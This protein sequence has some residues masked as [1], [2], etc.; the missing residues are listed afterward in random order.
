M[1]SLPSLGVVSI[2]QISYVLISWS[3]GSMTRKDDQ[4][5]YFAPFS[6]QSKVADSH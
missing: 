6:Y 2:L 5:F 3:K 4:A 1:S